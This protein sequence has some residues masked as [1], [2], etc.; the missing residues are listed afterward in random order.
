ML[1]SIRRSLLGMKETI[2]N[3]DDDLASFVAVVDAILLLDAY[4]WICTYSFYKELKGD[5]AGLSVEAKFDS[6]YIRT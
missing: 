3:Q 5:G 2:D 1:T 6:T 4:F